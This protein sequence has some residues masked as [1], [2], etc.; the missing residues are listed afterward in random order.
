MSTLTFYQPLEVLLL[1]TTLLH[2]NNNTLY[3]YKGPRVQQNLGSTHDA[4]N[5]AL[6][7]LPKH[8]WPWPWGSRSPVFGTSGVWIRCC[9]SPL[10][11][12]L[13]WMVSLNLSAPRWSVSESVCAW[14][15]LGQIHVKFC[16]FAGQACLMTRYLK[17]AGPCMH[18]RS[19]IGKLMGIHHHHHYRRRRH[20]H[21]IVE[22][23]FSH[24][25][26][27]SCATLTASEETPER[28][29]LVKPTE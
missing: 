25:T 16:T 23:C 27:M 12:G 5:P 2:N 3:I 13:L 10:F 20:H 7:R 28:P 24:S 29:L 21:H 4:L 18:E 6:L 8:P 22:V 26:A 19:S 15:T 11:L 14:T 17:F 9:A 1:Y